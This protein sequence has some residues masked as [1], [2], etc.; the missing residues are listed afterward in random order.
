MRSFR[1]GEDRRTSYNLCTLGDVTESSLR[2]REAWQNR[3]NPRQAIRRVMAKA[4][5][6]GRPLLSAKSDAPLGDRQYDGP[7]TAMAAEYLYCRFA[8]LGFTLHYDTF[9]DGGGRLQENIVALPPGRSFGPD[10]TL[11]TGHY[12]TLSPPHQ[13]AP[14]ADDNG[15]GL[16]AMLDLATRVA[17]EGFVHPVGFVAFAAEEPGLLGSTTFAARITRRPLRDSPGTAS[18]G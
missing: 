18:L 10:L 11:V 13:S 3:H 7:G 15:S 6:M 17:G 1:K 8:A 2:G 16:T 9:A 4:A 5:I 14:G 12:D